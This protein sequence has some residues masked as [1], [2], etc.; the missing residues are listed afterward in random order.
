M[1]RTKIIFVDALDE[2]LLPKPLG[3]RLRHNGRHL[4][5]IHNE[6]SVMQDDLEAIRPVIEVKDWL[7]RSESLMNEE[8]PE[9]EEYM[10]A[11]LGGSPYTRLLYLSEGDRGIAAHYATKI[12]Q[13]Y[14]V[15]SDHYLITGDN[16]NPDWEISRV[17]FVNMSAGREIYKSFRTV[18]DLAKHLRFT[19]EKNTKGSIHIKTLSGR[20][21][22]II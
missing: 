22:T 14:K 16:K 5:I 9:Y 4:Q 11:V 17:K 8:M 18:E 20:N 10:C 19:S 2:T 12:H 15:E 21:L 6:N 3:E 7:G 13:S 1:K